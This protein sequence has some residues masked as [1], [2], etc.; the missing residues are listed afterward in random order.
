MK[1]L[2]E[3]KA[4]IVY[5]GNPGEVI[6]HFKDDA[7]AGNG[8]KKASIKGKGILNNQISTI[9]FSYLA[10]HGVKNH[11]IEQINERDIRCVKTQVIALEVIVRNYA[12]GSMVKR[13]GMKRGEKFAA[14]IVEFSYKNDAL[15]DPLI[16]DDHA[17]ALNIATHKDLLFIRNEALQINTLLTERFAHVGMTLVDF[18]LEFGRTEDARVLLVDEISPD[19]CRFWNTNQESF[20]KDRFR[21]DSGDLMAGYETIYT[22]LQ[23][24]I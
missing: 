13:L 20:D 19:T 3:G 7:T 11:L 16:N 1:Q 9:L 17:V 12:A 23:G 21:E 14:P 8:A 18:K 6:I 2:Y 10:Q 4:K 5:E 15:G 24:S 22:L